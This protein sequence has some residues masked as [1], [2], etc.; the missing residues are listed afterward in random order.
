MSHL[1]NAV[2][3]CDN[4]LLV[5]T[6]GHEISQVKFIGPIRRECVIKD[7]KLLTALETKRLVG[8]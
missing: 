5:S 4:L 1:A 6:R 2:Q 7:R 3:Y 8:K